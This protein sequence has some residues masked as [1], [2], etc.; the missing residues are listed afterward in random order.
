[1]SSTNELL[2]DLSA[3]LE[4]ANSQFNAKAEEELNEAKKVGGLSA[5]TKA[6]VDKLAVELNALRESKKK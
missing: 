2:K 5:E 4:A 1:M 6:S 3:K